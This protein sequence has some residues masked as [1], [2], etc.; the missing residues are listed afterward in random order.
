VHIDDYTFGHIVVD[1]LTYNSDVIITP[2]SVIDSWWRKEGHRLDKSD[3]DA[4]LPARPD[5]LLIGT[6]YYGRMHIPIETIHYLESRNIKLAYA[7]TSEA[8]EQFT[9]LQ[10]ECAR[11]VAALHL[12]C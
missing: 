2:E 8:I 1:G 3:L 5:C 12:T 9:R 11:L 7:P 4:L 6:G 10:T